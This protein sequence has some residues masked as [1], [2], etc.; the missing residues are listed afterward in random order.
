M[1]VCLY[2]GDHPKIVPGGPCTLDLGLNET[3]IFDHGTLNLCPVLFFIGEAFP[4]LIFSN[5][6]IVPGWA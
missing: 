3:E 6:T 5:K 4:A 1:C 2:A